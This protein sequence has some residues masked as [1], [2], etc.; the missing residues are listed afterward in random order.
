MPANS[1]NAYAIWLYNSPTSSHLV[2]FVSPGVT[3]NGQLQ[4]DGP[5]P[6]NASGYKELLVTLETQSKPKA[7]GQ[8][9][10]QGS[11]VV[12]SSSSTLEHLEQLEQPVASRS[13]PGRRAPRRAACA[14]RAGA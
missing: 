14:W 4:T 8:V 7:P 13:R 2:G 11:L 1:H 10:L 3:S 9:V 12:S 5:L 6:T